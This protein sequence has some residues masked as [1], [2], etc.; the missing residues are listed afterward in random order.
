MVDDESLLCHPVAPGLSPK[1]KVISVY[2]SLFLLCRCVPRKRPSATSILMPSG[3]TGPEDPS[4]AVNHHSVAP[5][6]ADLVTGS[7]P[8][9][10]TG[11]YY[12]AVFIT[13]PTHLHHQTTPGC[14]WFDSLFIETTSFRDG[15]R[16]I[17][18]LGLL[19]GTSARSPVRSFF[20]SGRAGPEVVAWYGCTVSVPSVPP[21]FRTGTDPIIARFTAQRRI[22]VAGVCLDLSMSGF[23]E[24]S[25]WFSE[26]C[27]A[28]RAAFPNWSSTVKTLPSILPVPGQVLELHLDYF[29][30]LPRREWSSI[31]P[32]RLALRNPS[33]GSRNGV[34]TGTGTKMRT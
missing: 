12:D 33:N 6:L 14:R 15:S 17:G 2:F 32:T 29:G 1:R 7:F 10:G 22:S 9:G 31:H 16:D 11:R 8:T 28:I 19:D 4:A 20:R 13:N 25:V 27:V 24:Q 34:P 30:R 21:I 3:R 18:T 5:D 26:G 23:P